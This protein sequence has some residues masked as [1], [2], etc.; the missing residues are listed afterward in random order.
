MITSGQSISDRLTCAIRKQDGLIITEHRVSDRRIHA[1]ARS[2]SGED[3]VLDSKFF[4]NVVQIRLIEAAESRLIHHDIPSLRFKL[5]DYFRTPR[6]AYENP[7]RA[8]IRCLDRLSDMH[9][10]QMT[11]PAHRVG[12]AKVGEVRMKTHLEIYDLDVRGARGGS[13]SRNLRGAAEGAL[14]RAA[15]STQSFDAS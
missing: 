9:S 4:Q 8:A 11:H 7:T 3:E 13:A 12:S 14:I 6:V 2:T 10:L 5:W 1:N 15:A